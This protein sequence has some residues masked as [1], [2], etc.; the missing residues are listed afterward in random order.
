MACR[1]LLIGH[2]TLP[3]E[4]IRTAEMIYG[5]VE[6]VEAICLPADQD[7]DAYREAIV[8]QMRDYGKT[9]LL[10]LADLKGGTPF[11]T[12]SR[13]MRDFWE[14]E[15]ELVTGLNLPMLTE[16]FNSLEDEPTVHELAE[17]AAQAGG[18]GVSNF[19]QAVAPRHKEGTT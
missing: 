17:G 9:G 4:M 15:I 13:A 14:D 19:R 16:T 6:G 18:E 1:V 12:A 5:P 11:L 10:I 3:Q 2:G 7:M 8:Q